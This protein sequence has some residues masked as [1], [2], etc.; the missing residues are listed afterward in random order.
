MMQHVLL[1]YDISDDRIRLKV[2]D[3]CLDYGLARLQNSAFF[4]QLT[5]ELQV[6]LMARIKKLLGTQV[7][8]VQLI[9]ISARAWASRL[10]ICN[11]PS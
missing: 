10:E 9:P 2:A 8:N 6:K 1:I 7:G 3:A 5:R 4:G 11:A